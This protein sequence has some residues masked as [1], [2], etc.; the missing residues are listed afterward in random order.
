MDGCFVMGL[1]GGGIG[2]WA[3]KELKSELAGFLGYWY[4]RME[5]L[6]FDLGSLY[7]YSY[8]HIQAYY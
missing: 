5:I 1:S 4:I 6:V 3:G 8:Y 2:L 7:Y